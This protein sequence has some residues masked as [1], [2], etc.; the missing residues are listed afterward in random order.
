MSIENIKDGGFVV[1]EREKDV[2]GFPTLPA[3][4]CTSIDDAIKYVRSKFILEAKKPRPLEP[5]SIAADSL[6][7]NPKVA[8]AG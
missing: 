6:E 8:N 1:L 4:A 5:F 2:P 7:L 3:Y